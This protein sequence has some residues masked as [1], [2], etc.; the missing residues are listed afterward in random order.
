MV[1][2]ILLIVL[3]IL[4]GLQIRH[5]TVKKIPRTGKIE[6]VEK[7]YAYFP[8]LLED[9]TWCWLKPYYFN[10]VTYYEGSIYWDSPTYLN[11][12]LKI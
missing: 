7:A 2:I 12:R 4:I 6:T 11:K 9:N 1:P 5:I 10:M 3:V 8:V